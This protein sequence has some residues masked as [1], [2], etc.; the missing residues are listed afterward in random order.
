VP[1]TCQRLV[2]A[3]SRLLLD[4]LKMEKPLEDV[5][6]TELLKAGGKP[7]LREFQKL[8]NAILFEGTTPEAWSR[9]V[10]VLFFK[11][12]H[13]SPLKNYRP[14]SLVSHVYKL[15]SRVIT[16]RLVWCPGQNKRTAPLSFLHGCPKRRL[17]D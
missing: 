6:T 15:F 3:K 13:K 4:S 1:K 5:V 8:F 9:S 2:L 17:K 12:G 10:V 16:N 7:L 11:K 14:I